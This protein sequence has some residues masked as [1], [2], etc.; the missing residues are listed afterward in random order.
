MTSRQP[1]HVRVFLLFLC[2]FKESGAFQLTRTSFV[3]RQQNVDRLS[4]TL[5][6]GLLG[7][8][9]KN[10]K[11]EQVETIKVGDNLPVDIDVERIL[12]S[13]E[14]GEQL[15]EPVAIQEV[16]GANKALLIG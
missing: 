1:C 7:R 13:S 4:N 11:V 10:R 9:R 8:F 15:S 14:N 16:L 2:L 5:L 6:Y 3:A 12:T